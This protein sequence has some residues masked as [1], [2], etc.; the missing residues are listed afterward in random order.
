MD[1]GLYIQNF[2]TRAK[3]VNGF[4]QSRAQVKYFEFYV[5]SRGHHGMRFTHK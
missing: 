1:D 2:H 5:A 4:D 3:S